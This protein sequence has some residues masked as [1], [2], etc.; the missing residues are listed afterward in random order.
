MPAPLIV[1]L[2]LDS[3]SF[4]Q[5][6]GGNVVVVDI[7]TAQELF[8]RAGRLDR[9]DLLVGRELMEDARAAIAPILPS[10]LEEVHSRRTHAPGGG[11]GLRLL[12]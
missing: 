8:Q 12:P 4:R 5:A 6:F 7:S 3:E 1:R 11:D 2:I 10:D 9:I